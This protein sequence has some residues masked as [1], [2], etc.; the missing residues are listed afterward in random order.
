MTA[1]GARNA[2]AAGRRL[3]RIARKLSCIACSNRRLLDLSDLLRMK[4][5]A[6]SFAPLIWAFAGPVSCHARDCQADQDLLANAAF[7]RHS[8][9]L[10]WPRIG[11]HL[12]R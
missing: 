5:S 6:G 12:F 2:M 1:I 7:L 4:D 10:N 3:R 8:A 11:I 9:S